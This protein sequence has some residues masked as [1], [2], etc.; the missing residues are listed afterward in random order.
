[1]FAN[2]TAS[3][4]LLSTIVRT[5][6]WVVGTDARMTSS[7]DLEGVF[8]VAMLTAHL[9]KST[10]LHEMVLDIFSCHS[11][12]AL[13]GARNTFVSTALHRVQMGFHHREI[14]S[15][16]AASTVMGAVDFQR[17]DSLLEMN[18][19][20]VVEVLRLTRRAGE[21]YGDTLFDAALAVVLTAAD[22]LARITKDF[23]AN[24]AREFVGDLADEIVGVAIVL[25]PLPLCW[26]VVHDLVS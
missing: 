13:I 1:M 6:D 19:T 11:L 8:V 7:N 25:L 23:G 26:A 12:S 17:V 22:H 14:A 20:E 16:P 15:P 4:A 10:L 9:S 24:L 3:D 21:V 18:V 5:L 2:L